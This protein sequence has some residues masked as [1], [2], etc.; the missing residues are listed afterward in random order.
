[1]YNTRN[2]AKYI[3][4]LQ[5][6][7]NK[8]ARHSE[9]AGVPRIF[10]LA[11][12]YTVGDTLCVQDEKTPSKAARSPIIP[13]VFNFFPFHF[14]SHSNHFQLIP[15][16]YL[17]ILHHLIAWK[18]TLFLDSFYIALDIEVLRQSTNQQPSS[19]VHLH[20]NSI[21]I[22]INEYLDLKFRSMNLYNNRNKAPRGIF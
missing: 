10:F 21:N 14:S 2:N 19:N 12:P 4:V 11:P 5:K 8:N 18:C 7:I 16:I 1:M 22:T 17:L 13:F 9:N 20:E 6:N 3:I 15:L